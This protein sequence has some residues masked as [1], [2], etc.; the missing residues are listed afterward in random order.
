MATS[1]ALQEKAR[2]AGYRQPHTK[3]A[4][5]PLKRGGNIELF[6]THVLRGP[7]ETGGG[8]LEMRRMARETRRRPSS[9]PP[10]KPAWGSPAGRS[11]SAFKAGH[12][13]MRVTT[14]YI[15]TNYVEKGKILRN[16]KKIPEENE[17]FTAGFTGCNGYSSGPHGK[18][19]AG[20]R[21]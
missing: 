20:E 9:A 14:E 15:E 10:A 2:R 3:A 1:Y 16:Y 19:V 7:I 5:G 11:W 4:G 8:A 21:R 17:A 18:N 12:K 6:D 13:N